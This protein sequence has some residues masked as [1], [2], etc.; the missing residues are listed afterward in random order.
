MDAVEYLTALNL[1][2]RDDFIEGYAH[3]RLQ[4]MSPSGAV[5]QV[6]TLSCM[7]IPACPRCGPAGHLSEIRTNGPEP[8]RHC[9]SCNFDFPVDQYGNATRREA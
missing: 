5:R 8:V 1:L 9:Y 4:M 7:V 2:I 6:E 3:R